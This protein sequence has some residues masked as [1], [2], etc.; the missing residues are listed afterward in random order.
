MGIETGQLYG[1][2]DIAAG[3]IVEYHPAEYITTKVAEGAAKFGRALVRGTAD[4]EAKTPAAGTDKFIGVAGHSFEATDLDDEAY[5][6]KDPL[7]CIETGIVM[8]YV[9]EAV[10]PSDPVRMRHTA[11]TGK[12]AGSFCKTAD[13]ARTSLVTSAEFKGSTSGAGLVPLYVK[14]QFTTTADAA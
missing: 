10:S 12:E 9:E 7:A 14:G 5:A 13:P 4:D 3:K 1:S 2:G 8:V 11:V 6:E